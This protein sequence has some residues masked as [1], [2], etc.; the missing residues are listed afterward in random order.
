MAELEVEKMKTT[1]AGGEGAVI[2]VVHPSFLFVIAVGNVLGNFPSD[3]EVYA[4]KCQAH[5]P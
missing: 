2:P 5:V 3:K 1:G 4:C